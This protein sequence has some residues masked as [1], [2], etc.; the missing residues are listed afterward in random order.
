MVNGEINRYN[1]SQNFKVGRHIHMQKFLKTP[2]TH[3][4]DMSMSYKD[5]AVYEDMTLLNSYFEGT[6]FLNCY[7]W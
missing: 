4:L 3:H 5:R 2:H 6:R 1:E 7:V